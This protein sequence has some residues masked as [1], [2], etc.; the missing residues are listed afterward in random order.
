MGMR[1][2]QDKPQMREPILKKDI[3]KLEIVSAEGSEW[4]H[5]MDEGVTKAMKISLKVVDEDAQCENADAQ[6]AIINDQMN[7]EAHP[8]VSKKTGQVAKMGR[9]QLYSLERALGFDPY[10]VDESGAQV[11]PHITRNGNKACPKGAVQKLNPDFV[12]AYFDQNDNPKF[13]A[14]DGKIVYADVDIEPGD[15][16]YGPKNVIKRYR[17]NP[18]A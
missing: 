1:D 7:L 5:K 14:F 8:Y 2:E 4:K 9:G 13:G 6:P 3:C 15:E 16:Q 17:E 12:D 11:E 10:Y 18:E